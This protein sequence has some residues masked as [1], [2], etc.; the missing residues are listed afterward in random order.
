MPQRIGLFGG[1][2]D[3]PH[4]GHLVTA[5]NVRH[6][7]RLDLVVLMVANVPW[8]KVGS[9]AVTPAEDRLAMVQAAVGDVDGLVAGRT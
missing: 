3:P 2:F 8:Q 7:L 5:V 1:T 4:V 9:R 6:A